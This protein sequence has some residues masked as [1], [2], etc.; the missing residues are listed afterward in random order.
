MGSFWKG[1]EGVMK[2]EREILELNSKVTEIEGYNG[3]NSRVET[4]GEGINKLKCR[5]WLDSENWREEVDLMQKEVG[6]S[7]LGL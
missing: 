5:R 7:P 4:V 3:L 6:E 1:V 2:N